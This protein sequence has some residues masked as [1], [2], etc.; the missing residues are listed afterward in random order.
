[1]DLEVCVPKNEEERGNLQAL[2]E[3]L[4]SMYFC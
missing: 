4:D 1:M 3:Y 2:E